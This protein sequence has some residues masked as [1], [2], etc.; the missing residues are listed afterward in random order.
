MTEENSLKDLGCYKKGVL[1]R[2][3]GICNTGLQSSHGNLMEIS[4]L[5]IYDASNNYIH[6]FT[7]CFYS[8]LITF[9]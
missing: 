5:R 8:N 2:T 7:L 6:I 1:T 9:N 4:L 3:L